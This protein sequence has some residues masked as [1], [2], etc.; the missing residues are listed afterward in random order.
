MK[1]HGSCRGVVTWSSGLFYEPRFVLRKGLHARDSFINVPN[2]ICV[3]H[4]AALPS[5]F[6][7]NDSAAPDVVVD[8]A[9]NFD[10]EAAPAVSDTLSAQLPQLLIGI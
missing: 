4:N 2:L 10:L 1:K 6:L 5:N 7:P 9:A 8:V 3:N